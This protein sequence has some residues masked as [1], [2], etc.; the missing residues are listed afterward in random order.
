MQEIVT[1][2]HMHT[3][4][5]D[6]FGDH[7]QIAKAAMKAG[8]DAVIVT[9]HNVYVDGP[10]GYYQ[11]DN[12]KVL[13][14]M[15]EEIHD[16]A[17]QPQKNHMLVFG[18]NQELATYADDPQRLLDIV[19]RR[20]GLSFLA[21]IVDPASPAFHETDL[22]WEDWTVDG[23]TGIELWNHMSEFKSHLHS[24]LHGLYYAY[25]PAEFT[26]GPFPE[27]LK[28]W[29]EL[30]I[31][32]KR[33]VAIGGSD[34]H[35][36]ENSLGPL[37]RVIFPYEFHFRAINTHLLLP[38]QLNGEIAR[39]RNAILEALSQG[40]AFIGFDLLASSRGFNFTAQSKS[41][42]AWMGD[43]I[44]V[45]NGITLQAHLPLPAECSLFRNGNVIKTWHHKQSCT[46]I[47]NKPGVYRVEVHLFVRGK[48]RGWIFSNPI[49]ISHS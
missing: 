41:G 16:R 8:I 18:A 27:T 38:V 19:R 2:L 9:D 34:A 45:G 26:H 48:R 47:T 10:E 35:A 44:S 29:D 20:R 25:R 49:Y 28:K 3:R 15:G 39:D 12:H 22:S 5:S 24:L 23:F 36:W 30:L 32:G 43:A 46:Y 42:T 31:S 33:V 11:E 4:Y 1:N 13:L 17:R 40:H 7:Q 21:H 37:R 6:G 14:L